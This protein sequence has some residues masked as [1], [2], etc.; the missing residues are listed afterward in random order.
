MVELRDSW[1]ITISYA[2]LLSVQHVIGNGENSCHQSFHQWRL[3]MTAKQLPWKQNK[4]LQR[5]QCKVKTTWKETCNEE[6]AKRN[7]RTWEEERQNL[8]LDTMWK[9]LDDFIINWNVF[10]LHYW[11]SSLQ[12][13]LKVTACNKR[14]SY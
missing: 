6:L 5:R 12:K 3:E 13:Y 7:P 2:I 9:E 1:Q 14:Y 11:I 4:T 8:A 10:I